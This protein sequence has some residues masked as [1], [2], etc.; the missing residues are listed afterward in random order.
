MGYNNVDV[1]VSGPNKPSS[2][3]KTVVLKGNLPFAS[4]VTEPNVKYVVKYDFDLDGGTVTIP[5]GC[6]LE[7]DGGSIDKGTITGQNTSIVGSQKH[8]FKKDI[9]IAGTW[10]I[11]YI[12]TDFFEDLSQENALDNLEAL[13]NSNEKTTVYIGS[14]DYYYNLA[15]TPVFQAG[16]TVKS[17]TEYIF[18]GNIHLI[19]NNHG[20]YGIFELLNVYN[21][22]IHGNGTIIGDKDENTNNT[23]SGH[24]FRVRNCSNITIEGFTISKCIGDG[25]Y[26][27][28]GSNLIAKHCNISYCGRQGISVVDGYYICIEYCDISHIYA[29]YGSSAMWGI[30]IEPNHSKETKYI[31]IKGCN[32]HDTNKGI[33]CTHASN[34]LIHNIFITDNVVDVEHIALF[35]DINTFDITVANNTFKAYSKKEY[36]TL[37]YATGIQNKGKNNLIENHI[38]CDVFNFVSSSEKKGVYSKND[39]HALY[40][41]FEN[42]VSISENIFY[43]SCGETDNDLISCRSS[44]FINNTI[45]VEKGNN[46]RTGYVINSQNSNAVVLYNTIMDS[47]Y[48]SAFGNVY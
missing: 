25:V 3:Y 1:I 40:C 13:N 11:G 44:I 12:S 30:D 19:N 39:I 27:N 48:S 41:T 20:Y 22:Y 6:L 2:Q 35:C 18:N 43:M 38:F 14:G 4:Q 32:I 15:T 8:I 26:F 37:G 36:E 47:T 31:W 9:K 5:E 42:C 21:V 17:N 16:F 28:G 10:N 7:F 24:A 29:P 33:C 45:I 34:S 23:E 46:Y